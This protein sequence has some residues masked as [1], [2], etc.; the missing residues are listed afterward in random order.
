MIAAFV[1]VVGFA[2]MLPAIL[3]WWDDAILWAAGGWLAVASLGVADGVWLNRKHGTSGSGF[4]LAMVVGILARLVIVGAGSVV[5]FRSG[6]D[7]AWGFLAG[8]GAGFVPVQAFEVIWFMRLTGTYSG[9][10]R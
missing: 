2:A 8:V 3:A 7:A 9:Q 1:A 4:M 6:G 5:A 10:A